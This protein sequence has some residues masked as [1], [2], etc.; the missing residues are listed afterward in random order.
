MV[1][2][3]LIVALNGFFFLDNVILVL[4]KVEYF[5]SLFSFL[6]LFWIVQL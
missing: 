1:I 4:V 6:V 5:D 3:V 2:P